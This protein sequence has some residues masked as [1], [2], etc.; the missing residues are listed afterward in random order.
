MKKLEEMNV[1]ERADH[2][3]YLLNRV[4]ELHQQYS[5]IYQDPCV[6]V[7]PYDNAPEGMVRNTQYQTIPAEVIL[8][9]GIRLRDISIASATLMEELHTFL[10][11]V[12]DN[13]SETI[14]TV[15]QSFLSILQREGVKSG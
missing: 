10:K 14:Q 12:N 9:Q 11:T 5:K 4:S 2:L 15:R 13:N 7:V 3:R 6:M 8:T 1:Q